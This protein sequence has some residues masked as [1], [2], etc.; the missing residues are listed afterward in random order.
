VLPHIFILILYFS[1]MVYIISNLEKLVCSL[2]HLFSLS[3]NLF[4][5]WAKSKFNLFNLLNVMMWGVYHFCSGVL[6]VEGLL[7]FSCHFC[8]C[9]Y[10]F[11]HGF[12]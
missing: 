4:G 7:N 1:L 11:N 9:P 8:I 10:I 6:V 2:L 3:F 12:S 5:V